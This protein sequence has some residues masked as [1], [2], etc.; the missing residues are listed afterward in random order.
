ML[1]RERSLNGAWDLRDE[2]LSCDLAAA[3]NIGDQRDG[4]IPT[5]VPGDIHQGLIAAGRIREPLIGRNSF[6]CAWTGR[7]FR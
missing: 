2:I 4:W 7:R 1:V 5:P 3:P 6:D